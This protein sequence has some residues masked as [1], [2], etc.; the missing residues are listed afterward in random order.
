MCYIQGRT[1][2]C[3]AW[4]GGNRTEAS[5]AVQYHIYSTLRVTTS[6]GALQYSVAEPPCLWRRQWCLVT[7][8]WIHPAVSRFRISAVSLVLVRWDGE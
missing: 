6:C 8:V 2:K 4:F 1:A 7:L 3:N 5:K